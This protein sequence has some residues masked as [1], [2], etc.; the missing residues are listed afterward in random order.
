MQTGACET[1]QGPRQE[2]SCFHLV[3][4]V[5]LPAC[6]EGTSGVEGGAKGLSAPRNGGLNSCKGKAVCSLCE[7]F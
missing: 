4:G 2:L 6:Q 1:Q 3:L 5:P 7:L